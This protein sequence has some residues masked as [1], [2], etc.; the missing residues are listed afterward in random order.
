MIAHFYTADTRSNSYNLSSSFMTY[1]T[2]KISRMLSRDGMLITMANP[3]GTHLHKY[4]T[5]MRLF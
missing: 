1:Y 2:R 4:L 3:R 5:F